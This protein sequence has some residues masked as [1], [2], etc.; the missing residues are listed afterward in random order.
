[1]KETIN[2]NSEELNVEEIRK[3]VNWVNMDSDSSKSEEE[4]RLEFKSIINSLEKENSLDA[5]SVQLKTLGNELHDRL[6]S[7]K[8]AKKKREKNTTTPLSPMQKQVY[9]RIVT[10]S[11]KIEKLSASHLV[12]KDMNIYRIGALLTTLVE[13]KLII[14]EKTV[15][16]SGKTIKLVKGSN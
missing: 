10:K 3:I 5:F 15:G 4:L 6:L 12:S 7:G 13:K 9:D 8:V 11:S 1:M 16:K 2:K 14:M